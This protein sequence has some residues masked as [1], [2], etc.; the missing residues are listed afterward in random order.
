[1]RV[2]VRAHGLR[3]LNRSI[4]KLDGQL[5]KDLQAELRKAAE[6]V[7][8]SARSKLT[9]Y[10]GVSLDVRPVALVGSVRVRQ[11][12]RKVTGL[13]GDFGVLQ[14]RNAFI[15]ALDEN[16]GRVV[17]DLEAALDRFINNSGL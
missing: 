6:P 4:R 3:E 1:M 11:Q 5:G 15:P 14:M 8:A 12:Q 9:R 17:S 7:A 13:R 2:A 16:E 10:Q